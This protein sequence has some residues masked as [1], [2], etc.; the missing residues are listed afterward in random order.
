[1][2]KIQNNEKIILPLLLVVFFITYHYFAFY[3]N[4]FKK[5]FAYIKYTFS[6]NQYEQIQEFHPF[7]YVYKIAQETKDSKINVIYVRT[8]VEEKNRQFLDELNIMI[9]YFFYP[10]F[11]KPYSLTQFYKLKLKSGD[12]IIADFTLHTDE[13]LM[14][15]IKIIPFTRKNL[16]RINKWPEDDYNIYEVI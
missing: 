3:Q 6:Q 16:F 15:N 10:R 7:F 5:I 8:K 2:I 1:M 11:V 9:N 14:K 4:D 13:K 12:I